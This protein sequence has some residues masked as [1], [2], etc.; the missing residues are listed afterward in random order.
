[1]VLPR[2]IDRQM[3]GWGQGRL[4]YRVLRIRGVRAMREVV[5]CPAAQNQAKGHRGG[6]KKGVFPSKHSPMAWR[7]I[8]F[9]LS[10]VLL[11]E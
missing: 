6:E 8:A 3:E 2:G 10:V 7:K 1:M 5:P 9:H 11:G 4:Q